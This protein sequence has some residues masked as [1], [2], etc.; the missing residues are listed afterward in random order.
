MERNPTERQ[1]IA[2]QES[3]EELTRGQDVQ[4]DALFVRHGERTK[5]G[6][7]TDYGREVSA[8]KAGEYAQELG[9]YDVVKAYGSDA[10]AKEGKM[11][12][13]RETADIYARTIAVDKGAEQLVTRARDALS[14]MKLKSPAP[15]DHVAI[16]DSYLPENFTELPDVEKAAAAKIAQDKVVDHVFGL[17]TPEARVYKA[18]VAGAYAYTL[19]QLRKMAHVLKGGSRA[20]LPEG[21]HG[22]MIEFLFERALVRTSPDGTVKEGIKSP[23]E[24]GGPLDP[25]EGFKVAVHTDAKGEDLPLELKFME[26]HRPQE[27]TFSLREDVLADLAAQYLKLHPELPGGGDRSEKE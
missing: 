10:Q 12:R 19:L 11:G 24:L 23:A 26:E 8:Q 6:E 9:S 5:E 16:Y 25:S 14:Y 1:T 27:D 15:Y 4:I 17:D 22:G 18:E 13:S 2:T 21:T 7:L 3:K 20:L